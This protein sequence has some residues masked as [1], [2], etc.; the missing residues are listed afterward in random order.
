MKV[1]I[2]SLFTEA[3]VNE[4]VE[5]Y[6]ETRLCTKIL[7]NTTSSQSNDRLIKIWIGEENGFTKVWSDEDGSSQEKEKIIT[8]IKNK[9]DAYIEAENNYAYE[10]GL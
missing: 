7:F 1:K 5:Y 9:I 2:Y 6:C 4:A 3:D 8:E 10:H